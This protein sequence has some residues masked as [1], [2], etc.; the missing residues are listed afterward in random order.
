VAE[1]RLTMGSVSFNRRYTFGNTS[2]ATI[3]CKIHLT[4]KLFS[5]RNCL[6]YY[7]I[8]QWH[9]M[10]YICNFDASH[11][12][13][14]YYI[15]VA[16]STQFYCILHCNLS[17]LP[18]SLENNYHRQISDQN[19]SAYIKYI[20]KKLLTWEWNTCIPLPSPRYALQFD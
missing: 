13:G 3:T 10:I 5:L 15:N 12:Y 4:K 7:M 1:F 11:T 16:Y 14:L 2:A 17:K 18:C 20:A 19:I 8:P 6:N 9:N